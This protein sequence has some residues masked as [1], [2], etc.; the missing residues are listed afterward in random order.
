MNIKQFI[1]YAKRNG[2]DLEPCD[3]F[4]GE[5]DHKGEKFFNVVT[6]ERNSESSK[7]EKL[8]RLSNQYNSFKV[9]LNGFDRLAIFPA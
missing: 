6:G 9:E 3:H 8:Y 1:D 2:I 4:T 5:H 7:L